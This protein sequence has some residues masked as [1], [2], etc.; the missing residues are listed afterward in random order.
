MSEN[1]ETQ[2]WFSKCLRYVTQKPSMVL[3]MERDKK[4]STIGSKE[5][6]DKEDNGKNVDPTTDKEKSRFGNLSD[7]F[8]SF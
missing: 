5:Q 2:S 1:L 3:I 6:A 7:F 8:S 4:G